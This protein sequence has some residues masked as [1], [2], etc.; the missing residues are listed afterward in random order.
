MEKKLENIITITHVKYEN[1]ISHFF[2]D[3]WAVCNVQHK[4]KKVTVSRWRVFG[5]EKSSK[6]EPRMKEREWRGNEGDEKR[7]SASRKRRDSR[8]NEWAAMERELKKKSSARDRE[9]KACKIWK[10]LEKKRYWGWQS[11]GNILSVCDTYNLWKWD[12]RRI[13]IVRL[14][15]LKIEISK[16]NWLKLFLGWLE[17]GMVNSQLFSLWLFINISTICSVVLFVSEGS[18]EGANDF[19]QQKIL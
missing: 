14:R 11:R 18:E 9:E 8:V 19:F 10:G 5:V 12:S 2:K 7:S 15:D 13:P 6:S 1:Q 17:I 4:K 3:Y 16:W